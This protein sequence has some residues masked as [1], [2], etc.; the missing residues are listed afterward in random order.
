MGGLD[1][2]AQILAK[3]TVTDPEVETEMEIQRAAET[4]GHSYSEEK[5]PKDE[6]TATTAR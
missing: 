3:A 5:E 2:L 4:T 1:D 6:Q